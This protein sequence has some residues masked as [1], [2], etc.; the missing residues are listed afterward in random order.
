MPEQFIKLP[1]ADQ[2]DILNSVA[3]GLQKAPSVLEK[4]VWVCWA[5]EALFTMPGRLPMAFKGGTALSKVYNI[6]DRFSEDV[7]ITLDYRGFVDEIRGEL[8]KSASK[9]LGE[10]LKES[11]TGHSKSVVKCSG[12]QSK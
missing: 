8:S 11:V 6:I 5:L 7:D 3:H 1:G 4:D 10:Q 12:L 9:K 2:A